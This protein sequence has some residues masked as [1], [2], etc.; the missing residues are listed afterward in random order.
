MIDMPDLDAILV[1][2]RAPLAPDLHDLI[3]S[4]LHDAFAC[5]LADLTHILVIQP[6]DTEA[7]ILD[8]I[9]FSPLVSRMDG[10]RLQPDWD[11]IE[12]HPGWHE[13]IYTVGDS[14]FAF[15]VFVERADGVLPELLALCDGASR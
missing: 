2:L 13:L 6:E 14:G 5:G 1:A 8:A 7:Q 15:L 11:Y 3:A 12:R 10:N 9:G 4:R